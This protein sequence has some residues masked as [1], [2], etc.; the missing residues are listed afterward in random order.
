MGSEHKVSSKFLPF[1]EARKFVRS[2]HLQ[3]CKEWDEYCKSGK[4]PKNISHSPQ[5]M[6]KAN[7]WIGWDEFFGAG[8]YDIDMDKDQLEWEISFSK[9]MI[10][11]EME[12]VRYSYD[13]DEEL[14]E[15]YEQEATDIIDAVKKYI[16]AHPRKEEE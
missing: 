7:G 4:R 11:E 14:M 9:S 8:N 10:G 15:A 5:H 6:Y 13:T 1:K 12:E 16:E 3:N 2:L